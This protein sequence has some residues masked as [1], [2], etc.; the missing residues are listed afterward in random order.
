VPYGHPK[1]PWVVD[2]NELRSTSTKLAPV[3][4]TPEP[5]ESALARVQPGDFV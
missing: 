4:F 5:Y 2:E 1:K 3:V